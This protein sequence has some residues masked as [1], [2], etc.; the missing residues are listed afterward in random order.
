MLP[1]LS[2][3]LP[4]KMPKK[5]NRQSLLKI[6]LASSLTPILA[7]LLGFSMP[8]FAHDNHFYQSNLNNHV[9]NNAN[10]NLNNNLQSINLPTISDGG[11]IDSQ[12]SLMLGEWALRQLNGSAPLLQDYWLQ[13]QLEQ[14]VWQLNAFARADAPLA[15]VLINDRQINAFAV[16]AGL[17]GLNIGLIDKAQSLDEVVSVIAHEIAHVSQRHHQHRSDEKGKQMLIQMG[18]LLASIVAAKSG[19]GNAGMA[20]MMGSQA[21]SANAGASFSRSQE[22]EADRVGMQIMSQAG[23]D[24]NA[25]PQFFA[26]LNQ[27]NPVKANAL[28]PSFVMSHPLTAERLSETTNRARSYPNQ[29]LS[30]SPTHLYR[31][32]LFEQ[33][34][35]WGRYQAKLTNKN[36][37]TQASRTSDGAKLALAMLLTD[38]HQYQE[39]QITLKPL[40]ASIQDNR[41][42]LAVIV[43]AKL[44]DAQ[45]QTAQAIE[46]LNNLS[47]L[48]P[49]RRDIKLYLADLHLKNN[50]A[51]G[52]KAIIAL[53]QPLAKKYPRDVII[54]QKLQQASQILSKNTQ[55]DEKIIHQINVLRYRANAQFWQNQ[56]EDAITSLEQAKNLAQTLPK[57]TTILANIR[58]QNEQIQSAHAFKID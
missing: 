10:N 3:N 41:N 22:R 6:S 50:Q 40:Q 33:I 13:Q 11:L 35:W 20:V 32:Q 21:M 9:T 38:E 37:L 18:G 1:I 7:L 27:Q 28:I 19:E 49:E 51:Q 29:A 15:L 12:Q 57:N 16:P 36:E 45:G 30:N 58:E 55:N 42:P 34:Q 25:M 2:K 54:W 26:T 31:K 8:V 52:A 44:D 48:L 23:Y 53:L 56:L 14:V 46:K 47:N 17:I 4:K 5:P 24:V 43:S 39:A